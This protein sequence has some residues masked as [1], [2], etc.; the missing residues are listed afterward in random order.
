LNKVAT[1]S[2]KR[3][4]NHEKKLVLFFRLVCKN[5]LSGSTAVETQLSRKASYLHK[6][7]QINYF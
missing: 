6:F 1:V 5:N 4:R 3:L 2:H 7:Y